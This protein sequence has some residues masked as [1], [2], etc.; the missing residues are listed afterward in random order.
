MNNVKFTGETELE[1]G[2]GPAIRK[3]VNEY[4]HDNGI[5]TK[6]NFTL[7]VQTIVMLSLYLVPFVLLLIF[8]MNWWEGVIMAMLMGIG[9]AGIG[10]CVMHDAAHGSFSH[11]DWVNTMF[12][13]TLYLLGGNVF[14]WKMQHNVFHHAYTNIDGMDEDIASRGP[15]RL[16]ENAPLKKIHKYQYIHAFF[17]YGLL[18]VSKLVK[19]FTQLAEY[20][21][22]GITRK[23]HVNPTLEY[24]KM[25]IHKLVYLTLIIGLPIYFS[26]FKWWQVVA[27]FFI[28]HWVAGFILSTVFQMAHVVEGAEEPL[29]DAKGV[30]HHDWAVH[31]L[32]TTSN[33]APRNKLLNWYVGGLNFQIEHHLFPNISHVHYRKIAPIVEQTAKEFGIEY[34]LKPTFRKALRS[35][36]I[37]LKELGITPPP[38]NRFAQAI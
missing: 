24:T 26:P 38:E 23:Y 6:G 29:P 7:V 12:G 30:I 8:P 4:F 15:L 20:N 32:R 33:F 36:V 13:G 18:T 3:R 11:K 25:V 22:G 27:G 16:S 37:R 34:N 10:M 2:F 31:E 35:H 21:L 17:F 14:N 28:M 1:H 19:D 9:I 5:S